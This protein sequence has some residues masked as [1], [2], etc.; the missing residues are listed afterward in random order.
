MI[1]TNVIEFL[2]GEVIWVK[3]LCLSSQPTHRDMQRESMCEMQEKRAR[4]TNRWMCLCGG[5]KV[6][7]DSLDLFVITDS[8]LC[9][10]SNQSWMNE[11]GLES[12]KG[13]SRLMLSLWIYKVSLELCCKHEISIIG[14][15]AA[16]HS[17]TMCSLLIACTLGFSLS[18]KM[19]I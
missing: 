7:R 17:T 9:Q 15:A 11:I 6:Y 14:T 18:A 13:I 8:F 4:R 19:Q 5:P 12:R 2:F 3:G 1:V 16:S 10:L